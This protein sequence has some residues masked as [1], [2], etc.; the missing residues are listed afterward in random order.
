MSIFKSKLVKAGK[1][2]SEVKCFFH[3]MLSAVLIRPS[4]SSS[5][6]NIIIHKSHIDNKRIREFLDGNNLNILVKQDYHNFYAV[7]GNLSMTEYG[8]LI[9]NYVDYFSDI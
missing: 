2:G 8:T 9:K 6:N 7:A 4:S 5:Y 1:D 3:P